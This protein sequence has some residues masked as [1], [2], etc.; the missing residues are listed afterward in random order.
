MTSLSETSRFSSKLVH[1]GLRYLAT[2]DIATARE[3]AQ[4]ASSPHDDDRP[5][6]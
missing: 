4:R 1:G 3:S 2:G 5:R 6:I